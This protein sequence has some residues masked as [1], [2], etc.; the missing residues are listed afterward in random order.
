MLQLLSCSEECKFDLIVEG[1]D[2][3]SIAFIYGLAGY[4]FDRSADGIMVW[5]VWRVSK[6]YRI[7][8]DDCSLSEV[9]VVDSP[10]SYVCW[11]FHELSES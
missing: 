1:L 10:A 9:E 8:L 5:I 7:F 11:F 4:L 6:D 3:N 2:S